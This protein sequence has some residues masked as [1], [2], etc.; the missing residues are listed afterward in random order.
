M[1][2]DVVRNGADTLLIGCVVARFFAH[3]FQRKVN[4]FRHDQLRKRLNLVLL[5]PGLALTFKLVKLNVIAQNLVAGEYLVNNK[6]RA[7][8]AALQLLKILLV[9]GDNVKLNIV[10]RILDS[11]AVTARN[12]KN[13]PHLT[14]V[15]VIVPHQVMDWGFR[16]KKF[17][18]LVRVNAGGQGVFLRSAKGADA[19]IAA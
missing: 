1:V 4:N 19:N 10:L 13:P 3:F 14:K 9:N 2:V 7:V 5:V 12:G 8:F 17:I 18:F 15:D 16:N 6:P 11:V